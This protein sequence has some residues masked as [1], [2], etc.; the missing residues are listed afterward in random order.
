M[1]RCIDD[2]WFPIAPHVVHLLPFFVLFSWLHERFRQSAR[3]S[4]PDTVTITAREAIAS[5]SGNNKPHHLVRLGETLR[6]REL[7]FS[8]GDIEEIITLT[9]WELREIDE[10]LFVAI[11][12]PI[13]EWLGHEENIEVVL[14]Q[15]IFH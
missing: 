12:S 7:H 2:D 11:R 6:M 10:A 9:E 1:L 4:D 3:R 15:S 13:G 14:L 8:D 5:S